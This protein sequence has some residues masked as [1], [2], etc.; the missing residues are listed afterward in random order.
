MASLP[1][2]SDEQRA[3]IQS[4][5]NN[6]NVVVNSVAG[7]GKTT[8]SLHVALAFPKKNILLLTYNRKLKEETRSKIA[9]MYIKNLEAHS[10]HAFCV[11]Y[12][13]HACFTDEPIRKLIKAKTKP[14]QEFNYDLIIIDES[15]DLTPLLFQLI[16]YIYF[17]NKSKEP[18]KLIILGDRKQ[19]IYQFNN[20][21]ERFISMAPELFQVNVYPWE[22]LT[23]SQSFRITYKMSKF[24]NNG[25]S[26]SKIISSK[27]R[28]LNKPRYLIFN[29][30]GRKFNKAY[31]EVCMY[32]RNGYSYND[33]FIL[34]PSTRSIKSPVRLLANKLS[35]AGVPIFVPNSDEE[36]IDES[37]VGGK[38][39]FS[40]FHQAKGLERKI[41]IIFGFDE[42][43]FK[44][45]NRDA[46]QHTLPN[47]IYV[48]I[49]RASEHLTMI[50]H[51][52]N[53]F[54]PFIDQRSLYAT[55]EVSGKVSIRNDAKT[56]E[57]N[58]CGVIELL[59]HQLDETLDECYERLTIKNIRKKN[60][61][62]PI[63]S[64]TEQKFG[65]ENVSDITG[66]AIPTYL[67]YQLKG[68]ISVY[69]YIKSDQK[70][71]EKKLEIDINPFKNINGIETKTET[72]TDP[73]APDVSWFQDAQSD[74]SDDEVDEFVETKINFS[75]INISKITNSELLFLANIWKA[76]TSGFNVS[77]NQIQNYQWLSQEH[78]DKC[79]KRMNRLNIS[80][81]A[82]FE[83][84][85]SHHNNEELQNKNL[86]G[87]I[88][89]VETKDNTT[90]IYEFKCVS[91]LKKE[92]YLQLAI[93]MYLY[94]KKYE[95]R[96]SINSLPDQIR[97][98]YLFNILTNEMNRV[99]CTAE[100]LTAIIALLIDKK[101]NKTAKLSDKAF[102]NK[103]IRLRK[104]FIITC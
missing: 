60:T 8:A 28:T 99:Q 12:F 59:R 57:P 86:S 53:N 2:P 49:T 41:V 73:D 16:I 1:K 56:Q 11:R 17:H 24:I 64:K 10:F 9:D 20:A 61:I 104:K 52:K 25:C 22:E 100:N 30:F 93:Y 7:S 76:H 88:D 83:Q 90:K 79:M 47:E 68:S 31:D 48:A 3:I 58:K 101:Y 72:K 15:Q 39:V 27:K 40:S 35:Y 38:V 55:C 37:V 87:F 85:L 43:Y 23:L 92:H 50:H 71:I 89:C 78:L 29:T 5:I 13:D 45:Y 81:T 97:K 18:A 19:S 98:Y 14:L 4:L 66:I 51:D 102:L 54:L 80:N 44:Y 94:E 95:Q 36:Q 62:I 70:A 46:N 6:N 96:S 77:F 74:S 84:R 91:K 34:A 21:D 33:I 75:D 67:E 42:N 63:V 65:Y 26:Q 32:I 69:S 82:I 103:A